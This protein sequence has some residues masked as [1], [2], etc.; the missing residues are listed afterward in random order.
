MN[1][2]GRSVFA[3]EVTTYRQEADVDWRIDLTA[4]WSTHNLPEDVQRKLLKLF[5]ELNLHYGCVDLRLQPDG[6]YVFFEVNPA[7]QFL[8][9][10]ID[11]GQ[12][13]TYAMA[14]LLAK[15]H[16]HNTNGPYTKSL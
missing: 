3:A 2:F 14:H 8:F 15:P 5:D 4:T 7:G 11:T 16:L 10:E 1:I 6:V 9:I 12:P 13:L